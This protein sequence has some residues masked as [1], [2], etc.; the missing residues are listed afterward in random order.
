MGVIGF[1][2]GWWL[3]LMVLILGVGIIVLG[4][5]GFVVFGLLFGGIL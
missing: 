3:V 5:V 4:I 1:V 2:F